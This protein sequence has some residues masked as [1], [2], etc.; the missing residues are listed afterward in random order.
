ITVRRH[1]IGE[2]GPWILEETGRPRYFSGAGVL[3]RAF[4]TST[5]PTGAEMTRLR[6]AIV[7]C[8]KIADQHVL[9]I[10]RSGLAEIV[11][12]CDSEVLMAHQLAERASLPHGAS[13]VG[14]LLRQANQ[15]VALIHNPHIRHY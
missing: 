2:R 7:G 9:A 14:E 6:A 4:G 15:Q 12:V 5:D 13:D 10:R 11:G 1:R 3:R 8:G